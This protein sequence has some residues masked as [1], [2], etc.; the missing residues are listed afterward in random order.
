VLSPRQA[1]TVGEDSPLLAGALGSLGKLRHK[2]GALADAVAQLSRALELEVQK[3]AFHLRTVWE[4]IEAV[5]VGAAEER[6]VLRRCG[7]RARTQTRNQA[8][9]LRGCDRARRREIRPLG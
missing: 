5:K 1:R 3:D 7:K 8:A 6:A 9:W 2:Q 4:L